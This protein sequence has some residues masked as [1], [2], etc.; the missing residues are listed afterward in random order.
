LPCPG[1]EPREA[2]PEACAA[3]DKTFVAIAATSMTRMVPL[4]L[5]ASL[6][7]ECFGVLFTL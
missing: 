2:L 3:V 1:N 5:V 4:P 6:G 7:P